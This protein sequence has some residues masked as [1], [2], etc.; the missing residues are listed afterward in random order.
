M[1]SQFSRCRFLKPLFGF[2]LIYDMHSSLPQQLS[3][4]Q[5]VP[6]K[7]RVLLGT[8]RALE[9]DACARRTPSRSRSAGSGLRPGN[10]RRSRRHVLIENSIFEDVRL[11][12]SGAPQR[13]AAVDAPRIF[14]STGAA[15]HRFTPGRSSTIRA[16]TSSSTRSPPYMRH[17]DAQLL[18]VGGTP[19]RRGECRSSRGAAR[20]REFGVSHGAC[21][22]NNAMR[23][24]GLAQ[25]LSRRGCMEANT[26]LKVY[27]QLMT[28][29]RWSPHASG[30]TQVLNESVCIAAVRPDAE[31][32]AQGLLRAIN[33]PGIP[34]RSRAARKRSTSANMRGR[35]TTQDP[36][37]SRDRFLMCRIAGV[38]ALA[39]NP[40]LFSSCSG[41]AMPF[42]IAAPRRRWLPRRSRGRHRH[43]TPVDHRSPQ[44]P[45]AIFNEDE[46]VAVVFNSRDLPYRELRAGLEARGHN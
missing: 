19:R 18:L 37:A 45:P 14:H 27:E 35:T 20:A 33:S 11:V 17:P 5:K 38:A 43:A 12:N 31:S 23:Y 44:R 15:R 8:F 42:A 28:A 46:S 26:P 22:Q 41:C 10:R 7:S 1:R 39:M 30:R 16:S 34:A 32:M 21:Q 4:F 13:D 36:A 24:T 25:V 29:S 40:S 6:A 2:R 9:H 3:N